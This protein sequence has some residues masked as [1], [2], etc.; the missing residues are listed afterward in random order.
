MSPIAPKNSADTYLKAGIIAALVLIITMLHFSTSTD[1]MYLHQIYQRSYYIPIVLACFWFEIRGGLTTAVVLSVLYLIHIRHDW[2]HHPDYSFQ[3]YAEIAM[4]LVIAV[5]GGYLSQVQRKTREQLEKAGSQLKE[6]YQKLNET[7]DRLRHSDR[8]ASLGQLSAG[9]AHEIRNPLGSIQGAVDILA[10]DLPTE[11]PKSE[12]ALIARKEISRLE[13]LTGEILQFS[14]PAPPKQL[15]IDWRE[16]V[17]A[18]CRLCSDQARRQGVEI[19]KPIASQGG[20]ILVDPEQVKQ[21]LLNILINAIQAQP[22]GGRITIEGHREAGE[23]VISIQDSGSGI[24]KEQLDRIF[25]PFFTT[26]REGTGLGLSISFQLVKNNGGRIW[27]IS[28]PGQGACFR[29][30]FPVH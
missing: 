22:G 1:R 17:D 29:V 14:K 3:Q 19:V 10:Q 6:A 9:I 20:V 24:T 12:F 30:S 4:Y 11:D 27:A 8:L 5:L 7:F 2:S 25:D 16:L 18:A 21:V 13:K 15:P 28:E 26:R 23:L